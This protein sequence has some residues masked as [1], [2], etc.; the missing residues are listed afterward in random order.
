MLSVGRVNQ[1]VEWRYLEAVTNWPSFIILLL[2]GLERVVSLKLRQ[3]SMPEVAM[4]NRE[5]QVGIKFGESGLVDV[6]RQSILISLMNE[7]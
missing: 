6:L 5:L 3:C 1:V 4:A 7:E 2:I